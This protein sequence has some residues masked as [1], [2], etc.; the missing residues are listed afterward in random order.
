MRHL[1]TPSFAI[2]C[3]VSTPLKKKIQSLLK[4][5]L[6]IA[7]FCVPIANC[8]IILRVLDWHKRRDRESKV[9]K[10]LTKSYFEKWLLVWRVMNCQWQ[11][12]IHWS[13]KNSLRALPPWLKEVFTR[14]PLT[15]LVLVISDA[16]FFFHFSFYSFYCLNVW[17]FISGTDSLNFVWKWKVCCVIFFVGCI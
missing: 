13:A 15:W 8:C 11:W 3:H 4:L 17:N 10:K 16:F 5:L 2:T 9:G 6:S 12:M 7:N 1:W 14:L